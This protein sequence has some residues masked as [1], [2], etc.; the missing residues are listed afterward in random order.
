MAPPPPPTPSPAQPKTRKK[1]HVRLNNPFPR[2]VPSSS[3]RHR[4]AAPPLSF[5]PSSKLAHGAH[6]FPV[7]PHFLLR[8]DPSLG[9][10]VSLAPRRGG[11][12]ATMW[13]T[14]P[15]VAFVS[16]ASV[17]TEADECRGSFALRDG[18][19]RLVPDRQRVDRI[20]AVYRR[21]A[22][23]DADAD[24]DLLRVA[25]AAFQASEHEQAR[26]PVVVITGV[27]SARKPTPS[28]S[29]LCGRRRAAAAAGRPVLSARYWILLEEKSDTQVAFRVNL[30]DYQWSCDHDRHATHPSPSPS[31]SPSTSP[32][33]HRAGSILRLR[34]STRVQRSSG[35]SKKKKKLA[36]AAA[37]VP[38]DREELAPLVPAAA[39]KEELEF[40]RVWMT[41][42]S[43]REER[44]YGFGEQFSRVEF[45]GKRVPVLV[46]EQGIGRGDQPIT[47]AANLVSYR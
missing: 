47:F 32:R 4:D 20:R 27:V 22:D 13:E 1:D 8:W 12:G 31:P 37:G 7:G 45:K 9:G 43:S 5:S 30:G 6:D 17:D 26:F 40:N 39:A 35:G 44:F 2:A 33:T 34:L 46:Q 36:F 19:A 42:A 11:G 24:A 10:A 3:L 38:A 18:R 28:P 14:V 25:G 21:D 16:A 41:L 23:A 29:C 15:G